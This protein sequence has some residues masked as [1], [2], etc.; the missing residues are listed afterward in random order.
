VQEN[1]YRG[2]GRQ[3]FIDF[4]HVNLGPPFLWSMY[5]NRL[6]NKTKY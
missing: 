1:I 2:A 4:I 5:D 3:L 6:R